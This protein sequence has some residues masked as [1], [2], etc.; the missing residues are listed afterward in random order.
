[1]HLFSLWRGGCSA[2]LKFLPQNIFYTWRNSRSPLSGFGTT[3]KRLPATTFNWRPWKMLKSAYLGKYW[4][5]LKLVC[6]QKVGFH[7]VCMSKN[8]VNR[9]VQGF[10]TVRC[11]RRWPRRRD[12]QWGRQAR[13]GIIRSLVLSRVYARCLSQVRG[14]VSVVMLCL[15]QAHT[16]CTH[17]T[18][19]MF[20]ELSP[21]AFWLGNRKTLQLCR[22]GFW[23]EKLVQQL[24]CPDIRQKLLECVEQIEIHETVRFEGPCARNQSWTVLWIG[25]TV[26]YQLDNATAYCAETDSERVRIPFC[27]NVCQLDGFP[28]Y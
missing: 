23:I 16:A 12:T 5:L 20:A 1:M 13:S 4:V 26:D 15:C 10:C 19:D 18:R 25:L 8:Q 3:P 24:D 27:H 2:L 21:S 11:F 7:L 28:V 22:G 17:E 6:Y 14:Y 9:F